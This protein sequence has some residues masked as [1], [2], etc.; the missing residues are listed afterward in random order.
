MSIH[1]F[2]TEAKEN[3]SDITIDWNVEALR[4]AIEQINFILTSYDVI[5]KLVEINSNR[6]Q[7]WQEHLWETM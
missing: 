7:E 2:K 6:L 5:M 4:L 3:I 1:E